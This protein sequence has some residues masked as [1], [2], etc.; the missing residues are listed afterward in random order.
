MAHRLFHTRLLPHILLPGR[1]EG[2]HDA[3]H[4]HA[5]KISQ[6]MGGLQANLVTPDS[7]ESNSI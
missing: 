2:L 1:A 3:F 6:Q 4:G 7:Q 5:Q